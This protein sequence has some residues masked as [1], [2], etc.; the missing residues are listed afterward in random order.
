MHKN[1]N[2]IHTCENKPQRYVHARG[3]RDYTSETAFF[4]NLLRRNAKLGIL[5]TR[6]P[7]RSVAAPP[8]T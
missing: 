1:M 3:T 8:P 2:A 5:R 6:R 4:F 7:A